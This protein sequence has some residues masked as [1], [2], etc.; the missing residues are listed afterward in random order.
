MKDETQEMDRDH[1]MQSLN[2][3]LW[4]KTIKAT[5]DSEIIERYD[6]IWI[7]ERLFRW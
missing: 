7:L 6:K 3:I 1:K 4:D 5:V 2:F